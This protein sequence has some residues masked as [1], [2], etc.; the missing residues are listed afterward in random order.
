MSVN[1]ACPG[2]EQLAA[3][4]AAGAGDPRRR[5]V[6]SCPRCLARRESLR[7]FRGDAPLPPGAD[8]ADAEA[9]LGRFLG[10]ELGAAPAPALLPARRD[11]P[12]RAWWT[13]RPAWA[14]AAVVVLAVGAYL[15]R[16]RIAPEP[17]PVVVRGPEAPAGT[18]P[19]LDPPTRQ[20]DGG[21]ALHW[22]PVTGAD[23]Y[24]VV[25]SGPGGRELTRRD[26]GGATACALAPADLGAAAEAT[27]LF[28]HVLALRGG[29]E[30]ARS[31]PR[32]ASPPRRP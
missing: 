3:W 19:R 17:R 15:A 20:P 16:D 18:A 29:D 22:T 13:P 24:V 4:E 25:L 7:L 14:A 1:D 32:L 11:R 5:H 21:L 2:P 28:V 9:R 27:T 8:L 6:E 10:R 23:A 12:R 30:I 26:T 31:L